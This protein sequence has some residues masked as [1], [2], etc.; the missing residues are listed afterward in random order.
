MSLVTDWEHA[1]VLRNL[2]E[3]ASDG[4]YDFGEFLLADRKSEEFCVV[5]TKVRALYEDLGSPDQSLWRT[6]PTHGMQQFTQSSE[7][8]QSIYDVSDGADPDPTGYWTRLAASAGRIEVASHIDE[9]RDEVVRIRDMFYGLSKA[10]RAS[11]P[12]AFA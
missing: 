11:Q 12:E 7:A 4:V 6:T 3:F 8:L 9:V 2:A 5:C 1:T 10:I